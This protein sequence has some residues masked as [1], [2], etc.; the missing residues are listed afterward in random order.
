MRK[1][2]VLILLAAFGSTAFAATRVT[3]GQVDRLLAS[4]RSLPDTKVAE[5]LYTLELTERASSTT[6]TRWEGAF[7][8]PRA[9]EALLALADASAFLDLPTAEIPALVKPYPQ[10]EGKSSCASSTTS[11]QLRTSCLTSPQAAAPRTLI[12]SRRRNG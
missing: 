10:P 8:G 1:L 2:A 6:L 11:T 5:K 9:R 3:V 12:T 4:I 7:P